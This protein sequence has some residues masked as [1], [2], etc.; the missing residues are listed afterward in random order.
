LSKADLRKNPGP[1]PKFRINLWGKNR[2]KVRPEIIIWLFFVLATEVVYLQVWNDD[3]V[4]YDEDGCVNENARV[5]NRLPLDNTSRAFKTIYK[6]NWHPLT[7]LSHLLDVELL[8]MQ[9]GH[10]YM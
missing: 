9:S 1:S 5:Q 6:S 10:H 7:W 2:F 4:G 8:G 3:D